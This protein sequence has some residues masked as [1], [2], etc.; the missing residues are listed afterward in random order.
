MRAASDFTQA[1]LRVDLTTKQFYMQTYIKTGTPGW[2]TQG[3][4][5]TLSPGVRFPVTSGD[6]GSITGKPTDTTQP[7]AQAPA[8]LADN[9]T[10]IDNTACI[11]FNSRGIPIN[12]T[13]IDSAA[14]PPIGCTP[15]DPYPNDA[16]YLTDNTAFCAVT[17]LATGMMETWR[18]PPNT[19]SWNRQ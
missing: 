7:P 6:F 12:C 3:A 13:S 10:P 14:V 11:V 1:R 16:L 2:V 8:C 17:V 4:T 15:A 18:T 19:V 5:T 9:G